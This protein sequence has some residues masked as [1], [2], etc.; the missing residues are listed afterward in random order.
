MPATAATGPMSA[1]ASGPI[2]AATAAWSHAHMATTPAATTT[3]MPATT[4]AAT[5][6]RVLSFCLRGAGGS[7][8]QRHCKRND[9]RGEY[10]FET[11]HIFNSVW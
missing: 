8:G 9:S 1:T 7:R 5:A 10:W 3:H 6:A 2:S 4:V 11:Q